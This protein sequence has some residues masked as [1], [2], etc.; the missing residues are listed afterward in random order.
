MNIDTGELIRLKQP[1]VKPVAGEFEPL[2][3]ALQAAARKK[4]GDADSATVSMSSGGRLS[5]WAREQRKKRRKAA[6]D[7]RRINR[8]K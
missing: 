8:S 4:L 3:A 6:R 1:D 5:K 2:P 7:A